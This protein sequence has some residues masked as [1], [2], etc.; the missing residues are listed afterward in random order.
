MKD[1]IITRKRQLRELLILFLCFIIACLLNLYAIL[2]YGGKVS[3]LF[4]SLGYV[5]VFT[6]AL[7]AA[8]AACR[9]MFAILRRL[10]KNKNKDK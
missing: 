7:Y 9:V 1:I 10:I 2:T 3:E 6:L 4:T 5:L 8:L